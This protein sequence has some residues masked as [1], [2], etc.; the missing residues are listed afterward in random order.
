MPSRSIG[1]LTRSKPPGPSASASS[2]GAGSGQQSRSAG[3]SPGRGRRG[4]NLGTPPPGPPAVRAV[5]GGTGTPKLQQPRGARA[6]SPR[7]RAQPSVAAAPSRGPM[8]APPAPDRPSSASSPQTRIRGLR[9]PSEVR[10]PRRGGRDGGA[11]RRSPPNYSRAGGGGGREAGPREMRLLTCSSRGSSYRL[12]RG[13]HGASAFNRSSRGLERDGLGRQRTRP[14][15][16]ETGGA[17]ALEGT[18][19]KEGRAERQGAS[20][21]RADEDQREAPGARSAGRRERESTRGQIPPPPDACTRARGRQARLR[22][23]GA[24][25]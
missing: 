16:R 12:L 10:A 22:L 23:H 11:G 1:P 19:E 15:R 6:A 17:W 13:Q 7:R 21:G 18:G 4:R 8:K 24:A 20:T 25:H 9:N 5:S 3:L 2:A 14:R